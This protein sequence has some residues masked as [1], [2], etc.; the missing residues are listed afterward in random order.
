MLISRFVQLKKQTVYSISLLKSSSISMLVF[1]LSMSF[2]W[3][4][5]NKEVGSWKL[6]YPSSDWLSINFKNRMLSRSSAWVQR[7]QDSIRLSHGSTWQL[8]MNA[9]TDQS[10]YLSTPWMHKLVCF[11]RSQLKHSAFKILK[12]AR[13]W[14]MSL[15]KE[16]W[17][18]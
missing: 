12:R 9:C 2:I 14:K 11:V 10:L 18:T 8:C 7:C 15:P 4:R 13:L 3:F 16:N 6:S 5:T 1:L 17:P